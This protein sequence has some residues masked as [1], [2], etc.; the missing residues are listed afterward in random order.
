[1]ENSFCFSLSSGR[2]KFLGIYK[3]HQGKV[4]GPVA[5]YL[6]LFWYFLNLVYFPSVGPIT[7]P[8]IAGKFADPELKTRLYRK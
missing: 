2:E 7:F 3:M 1:M 8:V 5:K 6:P 4:L